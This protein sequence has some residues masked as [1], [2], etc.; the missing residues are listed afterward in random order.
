MF[1]LQWALDAEQEIIPSTISTL[2]IDD[3]I[4]KAPGKAVVTLPDSPNPKTFKTQFSDSLLDV[5]SN[6]D[7]L[8]DI[9]AQSDALELPSEDLDKV[10]RQIQT[11]QSIYRILLHYS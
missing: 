3:S 8:K 1:I 5:Q 4:E 2:P 7:I 6:I 9:L 11:W 10:S